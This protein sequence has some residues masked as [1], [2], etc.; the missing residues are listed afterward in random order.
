MDDRYR[1][2]Y[3]H[4]AGRGRRTDEDWQR[5]EAWQG[6]EDH[7]FGPR[8]YR[9]RSRS[10]PYGAYGHGGTER[11]RESDWTAY[12]QDQYTGRYSSA[13]DEERPRSRSYGRDRAHGQDDGQGRYPRAQGRDYSRG[14]QGYDPYTARFGDRW[15]YG[16]TEYHGSERDW[17]DRSDYRD[18][19]G[20]NW[21][22]RTK[23]AVTDMFSDDDRRPERDYYAGDRGAYWGKG[24]K[25]YRRSDD[26]IREDVSD[27]LTED[28]WLDASEIEVAVSD[29]EVTLN[30]T[31]SNRADKRR[32]E[33]CAER[34]SGVRHV[35]NNLRVQEFGSSY[36]GE[37]AAKRTTAT[38]S[39]TGKV[40]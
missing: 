5:R 4:Q 15:D 38:G 28:A 3:S 6:R 8:D 9:D 34:I 30:G 36:A 13:W 19:D 24:P 2:D 10:R 26:R 21:W 37:D 32:A 16:G 12:S 40:S 31:V 22:E 14:Q 20:R 29:C 25:G 35:Q 7:S 23:D 1:N 33:D 17:R 39:T 18:Q 11:S 27:R